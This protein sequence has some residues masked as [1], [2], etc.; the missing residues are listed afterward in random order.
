MTIHKGLFENRHRLPIT[1]CGLSASECLFLFQCGVV[2]V[3]DIYRH[4]DRL[5]PD[6]LRGIS[7]MSHFNPIALCQ[8]IGTKKILQL[9]HPVVRVTASRTLYNYI[10]EKSIQSYNELM[11]IISSW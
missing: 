8:V 6:H 1:R 11:F 7:K 4:Y 5:L 3:N 2:Y 9:S 10:K